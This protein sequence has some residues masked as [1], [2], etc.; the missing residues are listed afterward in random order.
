MAITRSRV[1]CA[2][3][4]T[5]LR[6]SPVSAFMSVDLPTFGLPTRAT[7]P[8]RVPAGA[9]KSFPDAIMR[10]N[11]DTLGGNGKVAQSTNTRGAGGARGGFLC[12]RKYGLDRCDCRAASR[13]GRAL[14]ALVARQREAREEPA[15]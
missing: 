10:G 9:S 2:R 13:C 14:C 3:G 4:D 8:A 5:M 11:V 12:G 15:G 7:K 1:V 6:R